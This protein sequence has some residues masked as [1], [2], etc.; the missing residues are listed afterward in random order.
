M[1]SASPL[2]AHGPPV[3]FHPFI[4]SF[5]T[6]WHGG[7]VYG[8]RL[9]SAPLTG[10]HLVAFFLFLVLWCGLQCPYVI[11]VILR[12]A[13]KQSVCDV[14]MLMGLFLHSTSRD[15]R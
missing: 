12:P 6:S 5:I 7:F 10:E 8:T 2:G 11:D 1:P 14:M 15:C 4:H 13:Q 9:A 3:H